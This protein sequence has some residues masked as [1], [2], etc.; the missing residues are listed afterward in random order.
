MIDGVCIREEVPLVTAGFGHSSERRFRFFSLALT[1]RRGYTGQGG[2]ARIIWEVVGPFIIND[3]Q[4][5]P[6]RTW[7]LGRLL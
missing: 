5:Q 6:A 3:L 1:H 7:G 2:S 4:T